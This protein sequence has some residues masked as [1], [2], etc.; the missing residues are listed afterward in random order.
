MPS[1]L[2]DLVFLAGR[3]LLGLPFVYAGISHFTVLGPGTAAVA[4]RGVPYPRA[5][6]IGG[7]VFEAFFGA[8]LV[9]GLWPVVASLALFVFTVAASILL[10]D[11]WNLRDEARVRT[12]NHLSSNV[13]VLGGLL[14][15]AAT[16]I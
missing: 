8:L 13:G 16:A 6:F 3:L 5:V 1:D 14:I 11:F 4:A 15:S 10:L 12:S 2:P 7:S 9:V